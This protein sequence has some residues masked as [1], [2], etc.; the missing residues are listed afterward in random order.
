MHLTK[1]SDIGLRLLMYLAREPRET[2]VVTIAEVSGQ[3]NI[4]RN[5]LVKVAGR[6]AKYGCI[7]AIRGRAGGVRLAI[8]PSMLQLGDVIQALEGKK[9]LINCEQ[10]ECRLSKGCG[11]RNALNKA[12][13]AFYV[14]LNEYSLADI[15][16]GNTGQEI[17]RMHK[18]Y[19]A[20][21]LNSSA[22]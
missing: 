11:L 17:S 14:A 2:P 18:G 20:F 3:F 15:L 7:E 13:D 1:Y 9:E 6:L 19:F 4:P 22:V 5:H 12:H 8:D 10:L 21:H 16:D